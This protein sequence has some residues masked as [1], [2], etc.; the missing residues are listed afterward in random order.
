MSR[1]IL[2]LAKLKRRG[3]TFLEVARRGYARD[4]SQKYL[5]VIRG[6]K[7]FPFAKFEI[8]LPL[9]FSILDPLKNEHC[10]AWSSMIN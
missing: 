5:V 7:V 9:L 6:E 2:F 10:R 3:R 1:Y 8:I 4:Y